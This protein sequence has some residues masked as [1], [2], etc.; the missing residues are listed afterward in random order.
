M[1]QR[2]TH[3]AFFMFAD[4]TYNLGLFNYLSSCLLI[5]FLDRGTTT[6]L[7]VYLFNFL[8]IVNR[9]NGKWMEK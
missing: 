2:A 1:I 6:F 8:L 9:R 4:G 5:Y 3:V 7:V